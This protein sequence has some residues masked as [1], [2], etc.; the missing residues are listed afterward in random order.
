MRLNK[1]DFEA[2]LQQDMALQNQGVLVQDASKKD[3]GAMFG[4]A[5]D[6]QG[7]PLQAQ[8]AANPSGGATGKTKRE[9]LWEQKMAAK[10]NLMNPP[11]GE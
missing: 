2:A 5:T 11:V 6:L 3:K 10:K 8:N 9:L 7:I 1:N 4:P